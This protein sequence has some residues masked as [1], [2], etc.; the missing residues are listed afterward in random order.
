[1][2]TA[3]DTNQNFSFWIQTMVNAFPLFQFLYNFILY[4]T[5]TSSEE[6]DPCSAE[7]SKDY[8]PSTSESSSDSD[9]KP[10]RDFVSGHSRILEFN[11]QCNKNETQHIEEIQMPE[12]DMTSEEEE[13]RNIKL[14]RLKEVKKKIFPPVD[15]TSR[16]KSSNPD[17]WKKKKSGHCKGKGA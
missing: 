3:K 5:D 1:M 4:I 10:L 13:R 11:S 6:D 14:D 16:R 17:G 2:L 12:I 8:I 9:S 15:K 7:E